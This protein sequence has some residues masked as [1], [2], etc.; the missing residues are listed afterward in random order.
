MRTQIS[1]QILEQITRD[2]LNLSKESYNGINTYQFL[3]GK[4]NSV[5][6]DGQEYAIKLE[7]R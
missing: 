7:K 4:W 5:Y 3:I 1:M 6:I 2:L